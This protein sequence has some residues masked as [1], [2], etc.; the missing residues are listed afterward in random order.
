MATQY[1]YTPQLIHWRANARNGMYCNSW[2]WRRLVDVQNH[3]AYVGTSRELYAKSWEMGGATVSGGGTVSVGRFRF[4]TSRSADKVTVVMYMGLAY[5]SG[6]IGGEL[7]GSIIG[8]DATIS[9]GATSTVLFYYGSSGTGGGGADAP[10]DLY[11]GSQSFAATP[12]TVY[13]CNLYTM[14]FARPMAICVYESTTAT[15]SE[16]TAGYNTHNPMAGGPILDADR[17]RILEQLSNMYRQGGMTFHW[18]LENGAART[19][20]SA[21]F[22]NAIDNATT[23]TPTAGTHPG[24]YLSPQN[25]RTHSRTTVPMEFA[26]YASMSAGSGTV[27][28]IDTAGNTYGSITVNSATPQWWT[29]TFSI[30]ESAEIYLVPQLAGDGVGTLSLYAVSAIEYEA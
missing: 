1:A 13:E 3:L 23:G 25:H 7:S 4:R 26:C 16:S 28:L 21:T 19:R 18:S 30:P 22:I 8:L 11:V 12:S 6:G 5:D 9:G 2:L 10:N 27:R 17:Q 14:G 15:V 20:S 24:F 29:A